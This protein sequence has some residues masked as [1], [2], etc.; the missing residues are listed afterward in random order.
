MENTRFLKGEEENDIALS[1]E[2]ASL[3]DFFCNDAFS[4]SH[5]AHASTEGISRFLPSCA[6]FLIQE[7]LLALSEALESPNRPIAAIVGGSKISTKLNVLNNLIQKVDFLIIGGA[8]ANTMLYAK[9]MKI[10]KSL[11]ETDM[12]NI[13]KNIT[14]Q[15]KASNC[16]IIS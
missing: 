1:K 10:G 13:A 8:M 6:G 15:A 4:A 12:T 5:R 9:G 11:I 3:G 14:I 2:L 16:H 7:E